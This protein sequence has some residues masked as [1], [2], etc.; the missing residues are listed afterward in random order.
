MSGTDKLL[1]GDHSVIIQG[2]APPPVVL[3]LRTKVLRETSASDEFVIALFE[4]FYCAL[5]DIVKLDDLRNSLSRAQ[6]TDDCGP[7]RLLRIH[8]DQL[9]TAAVVTSKIM[10]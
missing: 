10:Q 1:E 8:D 3:P 9:L 6:T 7:D 2:I 5:G 4:A